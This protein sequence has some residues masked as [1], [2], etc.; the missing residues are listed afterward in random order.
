M[1]DSKA[2]SRDELLVLVQDLL[3]IN[4]E[5]QER[6][7]HL[8]A[9]IARLRGGS[10]PAATPSEPPAFVKPNREAKEEAKKPRKRRLYGFGRLR[11]EPT[12]IVEHA[13]E[14]CSRCGRR[15]SGG[16]LHESRQ[17]IDIPERPVE[18]VEHRFL[19]CRCGVCGQRTIAR[20]DLSAEAVGKSRLG[21]RVMSL[22]AY[23]DT[24]CRMPVR[25]IQ[26][27]LASV[28]GLRIS[29]GE[30]VSVLGT[31]GRTGKPFYEGLLSEARRSGVLHADETGAREDGRN[32]YLWSLSTSSVRYYHRD[33]SRGAA[34]IQ[35]LLGYDPKV[36]AAR[37]ARGV[38]EAVEAGQTPLEGRFAGVLV[39]DFYAAYS[40]YSQSGRWHQRCLVH[41]DRDMDALKAEHAEDKSVGV[42]VERVLD[43]IERAKTSA[44]MYAEARPAKRRALREAFQKEAVGLVRPYCRSAL[45]QSVLAQRIYKHRGELF[46]FV[47]HPDVPADNNA[48]ERAIRPHVVL[49][50]VSGGTRSKN[51]SDTQAILLSLFG[52]WALRGLDG[53]TACRNLLTGQPVNA[54]A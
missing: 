37:S 8:E 4:E 42:W 27:Y 21:V 25:T 28:Y 20:P 22:V 32:G 52:T 7:R 39:S 5:Q 9:E 31:V 51:G 43:L 1:S 16:W 23:L 19:A 47:E 3:L 41:L 18:V 34:V 48:A 24:V 14:Q 40:W 54:P 44:R 38:R 11:E 2:L 46:V 33:P 26:Q 6:I 30:I 49:R 17:I 15:L 13:P 45:P 12:Q 36:F 50:K 29:V 35:R 53:L 10:P